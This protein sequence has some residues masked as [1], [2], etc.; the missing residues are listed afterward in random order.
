[1]IYVLMNF[2]RSSALIFLDYCYGLRFFSAELFIFI[3]KIVI[4]LS[5]YIVDLDVLI[6]RI[7]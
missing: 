4:S 2:I 5:L 6:F 1:M 7:L 3:I